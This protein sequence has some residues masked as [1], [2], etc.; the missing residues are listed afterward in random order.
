MIPVELMVI[1]VHNGRIMAATHIDDCD[2]AVIELFRSG[3]ATNYGC[4]VLRNEDTDGQELIFMGSAWMGKNIS[5]HLKP[6]LQL[7]SIFFPK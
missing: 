7:T 1:K 2:A 3:V 6:V 4:A 5:N